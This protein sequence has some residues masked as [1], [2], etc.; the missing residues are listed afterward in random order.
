MP[1]PPL[2][3]DT[4]CWIWMQGGLEPRFSPEGLI[5]LQKAARDAN[6]MVS[7]ISVWEVALLESKRRISLDMDCTRWIREA[8][9][10]PGLTLV[11]L[12]PEI[13]VHSTRLPGDF[14]G[15]PADRIIVATARLEG[16]R[17]LTKDRKLLDYGRLRYVSAIP[18]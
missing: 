7:A 5:T 17:L 12:T 6:L 1:E 11:P 14:H 13:A 16:A 10:T 8:L 18:A 9:D 4:H 15:D 2:L 3:L